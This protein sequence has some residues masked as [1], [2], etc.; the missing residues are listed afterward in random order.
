MKKRLLLPVGLLATL[1]L[2]GAA[3]SLHRLDI[4][5]ALVCADEGGLLIPAAAQ[6]C[7]A[8]V[9]QLRGTTDDIARLQAGAG[10]GF[11]VQGR[12]SAQHKAELVAFLQARGLDVNQPDAQGWLPLHAS[13]LARQPDEVAILLAHGADPLR[14]NDQQQT[15]LALAQALQQRKPDAQLQ[16]IIALLQTPPAAGR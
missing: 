5:Q 13:I 15:A 12:A 2:A 14:V 10:M 8:Y 9:F 6:V 16:R 4:E 7:R 3:Y 11:V 1:Y